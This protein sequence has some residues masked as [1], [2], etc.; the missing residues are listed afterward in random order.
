VAAETVLSTEHAGIG[1]SLSEMSARRET[2]EAFVEG[3]FAELEVLRDQVVEKHHEID[4]QR[5]LLEERES[6][7]R[8]QRQQAQQVSEIVEAQDASLIRL[9]AELDQLKAEFTGPATG[10]SEAFAALRDQ[11]QHFEG[12]RAQL[13]QQLEPIE[14]MATALSDTRQDLSDLKQLISGIPDASSDAQTTMLQGRVQQLEAERDHLRQ[15]IEAV[16]GQQQ[17]LEEMTE[18]ISETSQEMA[19]LKRLVEE[20][21]NTPPTI[22]DNTDTARITDLEIQR[23][24]L[25]SE[26]EL[27]RRRNVEMDQMLSEQRNQQSQQQNQFSVELKEMRELLQRQETLLTERPMT[28]PS[29]QVATAAPVATSPTPASDRKIAGATVV[30][31]V[32]A[33]FAK[34][35]DDVARRRTQK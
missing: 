4:A 25:E 24:Q 21:A 19:D 3:L 10:D 28:S 31:S 29:A 16:Q 12:E 35:Q 13:S 9:L 8:E 33:Q 27:V 14:G 22:V 18:A 32:M 11:L 23:S 6:Q 20:K 2:L 17:P 7:L 26:L 30:D 15:Q 1:R 5:R 34:L